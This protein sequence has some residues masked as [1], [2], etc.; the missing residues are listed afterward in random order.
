MNFK[1][2]FCFHNW[3]VLYTPHKIKKCYWCEKVVKLD[4]AFTTEQE[5]KE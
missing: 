4:N 3:Q 2:L 5:V 1:Q